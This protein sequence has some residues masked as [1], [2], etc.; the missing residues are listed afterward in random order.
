M[1]VD[2]WTHFRKAILT[3]GGSLGAIHGTHD[4]HAQSGIAARSAAQRHPSARDPEK[5]SLLLAAGKHS[6]LQIQ[7]RIHS[8]ACQTYY[9]EMRQKHALAGWA[10]VTIAVGCQIIGPN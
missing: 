7:S 2:R 1:D 8:I 9:S 3:L 5:A 4:D 6:Y 10:D